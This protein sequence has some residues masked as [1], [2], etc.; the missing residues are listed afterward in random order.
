[1]A[2]TYRNY[3]L[4]GEGDDPWFATENTL[5]KDMIDRLPPDGSR[6]VTSEH[7]HS[8][9]VNPSTNA[10]VV[11]VSGTT[12]SFPDQSGGSYLGL[13]GSKELVEYP[14]S[15]IPVNLTTNVS[16][17]VVPKS[18]GVGTA[19]VDSNLFSDTTTI[20]AKNGAT[21]FF[22]DSAGTFDSSETYAFFGSNAPPNTYMSVKK[23][24]GSGGAMI[25]GGKS[26]SN[27]TVATQIKGLTGHDP[28]IAS[29]IIQGGTCVDHSSSTTL[30][31]ISESASILQVRNNSTDAGYLEVKGDGALELLNNSSTHDM[32]NILDPDAYCKLGRADTTT[33]FGGQLI[34]V[35]YADST[36]SAINI[37]GLSTTAVNMTACQ[38]IGGTSDGVGGYADAT[39][40]ATLLAVSNNQTPQFT[41]RADGRINAANLP[42]WADYLTLATGDIYYCTAALNALYIK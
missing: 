32:T 33:Y 41:I 17:N 20:Q 39:A 1:M 4:N 15:G 19:L 34:G 40:S 29:V 27:S 14:L 24:A 7:Y 22:V 42:E 16:L 21:L 3:T 26:H 8:A 36:Q 23:I 30:T 28:M 13:N 6:L 25:T 38:I 35:T 12:V 2:E 11:S 37:I 10:T 31:D 9:L 5:Q 18:Q